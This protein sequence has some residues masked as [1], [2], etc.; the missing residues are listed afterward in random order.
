[1]AFSTLVLSQKNWNS[2]DQRSDFNYLLPTTVLERFQRPYVKWI[3]REYTR[4]QRGIG[5]IMLPITFAILSIDIT[6][7]T[8]YMCFTT[9]GAEQIPICKFMGCDKNTCR[10]GFRNTILLYSSMN[11]LYRNVPGSFGKSFM[12][13]PIRDKKGQNWSP[14]NGVFSSN[15]ICCVD[16]PFSYTFSD[17]KVLLGAVHSHKES[18]VSNYNNCVCKLCSIQKDCYRKRYRHIPP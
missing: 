3:E 5:L 8:F 14:F 6:V 4:S 13:R 10:Y 1:M 12:R 16:L 9:A 2:G 15:R 11:R 7:S 17:T 18:S